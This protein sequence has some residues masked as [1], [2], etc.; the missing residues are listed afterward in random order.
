MIVNYISFAA[1]WGTS[2]VLIAAT[3]RATIRTNFNKK[4]SSRKTH[5]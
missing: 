3:T 4:K 1:D 2:G 5:K